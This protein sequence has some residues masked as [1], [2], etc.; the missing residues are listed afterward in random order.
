[1]IT[2]FTAVL[3]LLSFASFSNDH[4]IKYDYYIVFAGKFKDDNISV[5]INKKQVLSNC[6]LNNDDSARRGNL[7]IFQNKDSVFI[8]Y[9]GQQATISKIKVDFILQLDVTVNNK[10]ATFK[11]DLKKGKVILIDYLK[12]ADA[13]GLNN[14]TIE[15]IQEQY[16]LI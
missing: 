5:S 14:L 12:K 3:F 7:N 10:K 16:L 15:Q 2:Y 11:I 9:N 13:P 4:T 6:L 1:M 8:T